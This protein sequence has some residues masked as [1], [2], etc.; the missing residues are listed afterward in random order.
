M[1]RGQIWLRRN[2]WTNVT[3]R[4]FVPTQRR[5]MQSRLLPRQRHFVCLDDLD[6][7]RVRHGRHGALHRKGQHVRVLA[8]PILVAGTKA[9]AVTPTRIE[10]RKHTRRTRA[11]VHHCEAT[12]GFCRQLDSEDRAVSRVPRQ[13][14]GVGIFSASLRSL[15]R[16][17]KRRWR[18]GCAACSLTLHD[19]AP[20]RLP[21][22]VA[23]LDAVAV[24]GHGLEAG[25]VIRQIRAVVGRHKV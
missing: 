5:T 9:C 4:N 18:I 14:H 7:G 20:F 3:E 10:V 13:P 8:P 24:Q 12:P 23:C 6:C 22:S 17:A 21:E 1:S 2:N 16:D 19:L 15:P 25:V 11:L